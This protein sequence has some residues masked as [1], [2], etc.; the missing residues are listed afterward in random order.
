MF[1]GLGVVIPV[2]EGSSRV[3]NKV[4][5]PF[6]DGPTLL[7]WK[8]KQLLQVL[9]PDQVFVSTDS[10][11]L[12]E[13]A[14]NLSVSVHRRDPYLCRGHDASFSEVITGVAKH[15]P[16]KHLAWV[17]VVVPLMSPESYR[18]AFRCYFENVVKTKANDSLVAVNLL[19][20]YLWDNNGP[21]NYRADRQH[22]ISQQLPDW[23]RVTNGLYMMPTADILETEY[24]LGKNPCRFIVPKVEG[25]DIDN[26]DDYEIAQ[27]LLNLYHKR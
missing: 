17:T 25:V 18:A 2:R 11:R 13:L 24:F 19:K 27:S 9:S 1:D 12:I 10:D 8:I 26:W 4:T 16:V 5:L 15:I 20:D 22:T 21:L 23:Y 7:E 6:G 14:S 3:K